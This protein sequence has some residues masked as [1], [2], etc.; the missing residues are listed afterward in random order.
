MK[1]VD[2]VRAIQDIFI[3]QSLSLSTAESCTGGDIAATITSQAGASCYF[4]GGIVSYSNNAKISLLGVSPESLERYGAVS[5]T[6]AM[7]M[8]E[9][10]KRVLGTD[11]ALSTTG[12]AGPTGGSEKDPVGTT[13][14]AIATP[15]ACCAH[16]LQLT[17]SRSNIISSTT[18]IIFTKLLETIRLDN[19]R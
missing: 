18:N 15:N 8:A 11:Y 3:E 6:V 1:T 7:E 4:L 19:K 16:R 13:W 14:I 17:G 10:A 5:E 12:I 9:G 2:L